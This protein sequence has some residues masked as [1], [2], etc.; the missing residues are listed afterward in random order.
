MAENTQWEY[1]VISA[2]S[3]WSGPNE[4]QMEAMLNELGQE[5]WE[6]ISTLATHSSNKVT[7]VGKRPVT[8]VSRRQ[9]S[10]PRA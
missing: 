6:V 3:F 8:K 1:R 7:F 2:G 5:G 9:R 4:E 10:W